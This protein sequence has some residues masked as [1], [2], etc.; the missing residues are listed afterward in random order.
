MLPGCGSAPFAGCKNVCKKRPPAPN[1]G[2]GVVLTAGRSPRNRGLGG[3]NPAFLYTLNR[4]REGHQGSVLVE[5]GVHA[6]LVQQ[7]V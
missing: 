2:G 4:F 3:A 5:I 6:R 7:Q 1:F